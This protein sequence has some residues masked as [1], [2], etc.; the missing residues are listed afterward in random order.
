[1]SQKT[2]ITKVGH[3]GAAVYLGQDACGNPTWTRNPERI[4]DWLCDGWRYRFNQH[5]E[6]RPMRRLMEDTTTHERM[7]VSIPLGGPDVG[8]PVKDHQARVDHP[9][10][11]CIPSPVIASCAK[12]EN[13]QWFAGL[14]RKKTNGGRL[15]GFR[16]RHND[17]QWFVCWRNQSKTGNAIYHRTGRRHGVVI[18]TGSIPRPYRK[19]G[20]TTARWRLIIHI[21]VSQPIRDYTSVSVN[22]T[23]RTLVFTN[24]PTP[25]PRTPT[26]Q[27]IGIDRGA[28][29]TL[30]LSDGSMLDMPQPSTRERKEYRRL[31]RKLARQDRTNEQRGGKHAK[32]AS[33]AR[34]ETLRRMRRIQGKATRRKNDWVDKTTTRLVEQYDLIAIEQLQTKQMTR[35]CKPKPDPEHPG[36]YLHNGQTAKRGLNRMI[37]ANRWA[38]IADKL[39]YKSR[40]AH[41][42]LIEVNPAYTSRT[43]HQCGY[44][45]KE[46]RESQAVFHCHQCGYRA[47]ADTNA[48]LNILSRARQDTGMDDAEGAEER[49]ATSPSRAG[50]QPRRNTRPLLHA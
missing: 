42:S 49:Q 28:V 15:P 26:G 37:L 11:A 29:H 3:D 6:H 39:A 27:D 47:N 48:A 31:Q 7:W 2:R 10:L 14:K 46:N 50:R 35:R 19:P 36:R 25:I 21:R 9:W 38:T 32:Y 33:H 22:W 13:T 18:I 44:E 23:Y 20:D 24:E 30:A 12:I 17:P 45:A 40:L 4:M 43:C 16:S 8:E 34:Q 41:V 5:R 1:M